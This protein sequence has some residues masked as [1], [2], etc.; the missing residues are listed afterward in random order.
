MG[1]KFKVVLPVLLGAIVILAAVIYLRHTNIPVL[2]PKGI[3]GQKEKNLLVFTVLLGLG[4]IIPT[5]LMAIFILYR[6][7]ENNPKKVKYTPEWSNH[8]VAETIWWGIPIIFIT[9]L[10]IVT[11]RSTYQLDPYKS[12]ASSNR[13]INI[14]VVSLDWKWLFIYPNLN[15]ASV[16]FIQI[17]NNTPVNFEIT[18]DTVMNSFWVPQLGGQIYAMPGMVTEL[19][20]MANQIGSYSG[21]SAN[22]S[23]EGFAGMKFTIK[24]SSAVNFSDWVKSIKKSNSPLNLKTYTNLAKASIN[25]PITYYSTVNSSLYDMI[26]TKYMVPISASSY[27]T[28]LRGTPKQL[29]GAKT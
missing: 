24:S 28:T 17:P 12:L 13:Q 15:I 19:N 6:Y 25:N 10:S 5:F 27:I 22:I 21:S 4:I 11:W 1:K 23:G 7:R 8:K 16:N 29:E 9:I 26:V 18:S 2:E 3:V 14:Q 20:L